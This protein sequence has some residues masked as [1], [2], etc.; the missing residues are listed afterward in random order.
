MRVG[1]IVDRLRTKAPRLRQVI[2]ALTGAVPSQYP[3]AYV[4]PVSE[5]SDATALLGAHDQRVRVEIAVEIMVRHAMDA[6]T[7]GPAAEELEDVRDE[8][9][10]ALAGF[11]PESG[12]K[13]LDHVEGRAMSFEAGLV[14]WRDTWVTE[15]YR[16]Q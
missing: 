10:S 3:A 2:P 4:F 11:T 14:I 8:V 13:P 6:A 7:G 12:M 5:R 15:F 16:R 1:P 9:R